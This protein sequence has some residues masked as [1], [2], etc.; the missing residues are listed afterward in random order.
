MTEQ[1][2][3]DLGFERTDVS[4]KESGDKALHYYTL[5]L[6]RRFELISNASNE[7]GD[8]KWYVEFFEAD[9]IRFV[10]KENLEEFINIVKRNKKP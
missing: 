7:A 6:V 10:E 3:I 2:L 4:A 1:D 8:G 5:D 9:R